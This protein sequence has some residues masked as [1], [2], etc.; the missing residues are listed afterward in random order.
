[1]F[2]VG[3]SAAP[4]NVTALAIDS[5]SI[6][7]SW[8]PPSFDQQNGLIRH[9]IINVTEEDTGYSF[10]QR[11]TRTEF[12]FYSLHPHYT[13]AFSVAAETIEVGPP[14]SILTTETEEDGK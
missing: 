12:S 8:D 6:L 5:Q 3:P 13:Y 7:V 4:A 10:M 1:M 11:T 9:Y 14:S 2:H